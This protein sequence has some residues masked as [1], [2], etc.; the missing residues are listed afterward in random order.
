MS[1]EI[2]NQII[3][4]QQELKQLYKEIN[5]IKEQYDNK[6]SLAICIEKQIKILKNL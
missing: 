2:D 4:L 1:I 5:T 6:K 3:L